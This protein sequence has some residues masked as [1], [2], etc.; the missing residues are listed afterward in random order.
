MRKFWIALIIPALLLCSC[1]APAAVPTPAP[2]ATVPPEPTPDPNILFFDDFDGD[3]LDE[4][5]W[6]VCPRQER[7]GGSFWLPE[8]V[9]LD[10]E[11]HL[12]LSA[13]EPTYKDML[14]CGAIRSKKKFENAYG[15][16]EASIRFPVLRGSWGAFWL[17]GDGVTSE[18]DEGR[19]GTEID[20][21]ESIYNESGTSNSALH[22]DGYGDAHR[23][24]SKSYYNTDI[25]DGEFHTFA[26]EWTETEYVFYIDG[27]EMWRT[28]AGGICE[29]PLYMKLSMEAATWAG[30]VDTEK[31]PQEMLVDYVLVTREK[32]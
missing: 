27:E 12:V 15:Y 5:K 29:V 24:T 20:I 18:A 21:I 26:L 11:G 3:A 2:T 7:H 19:D 22:W 6:S 13:T 4:T 10:G 9:S 17:Y 25:Y 8:N 14:N 32:P 16:Y 31:L 30:I 28:D 1:A 23:T